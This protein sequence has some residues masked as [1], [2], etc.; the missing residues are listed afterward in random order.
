MNARSIRRRTVPVRLAA[1]AAVAGLLAIAGPPAPA[2]A[3]FADR[4]TLPATVDFGSVDLSASPVAR[5]VQ[6]V[7]LRTRQ[8]LPTAPLSVSVL[9]ADAADFV[10][11]ADSC[12]GRIVLGGASCSVTLAFAPTAAGTKSATLKIEGLVSSAQSA[13]AGSASTSTNPQGPYPYDPGPT[14]PA[15]GP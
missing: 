6:T 9:G 2:S 12:S 4:F 14:D 1:A 11:T 13:L 7:T 15:A 8:L 10:V 5:P 3:A